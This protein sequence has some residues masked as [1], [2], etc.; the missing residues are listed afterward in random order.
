MA[1][2]KSLLSYAIERGVIPPPNPLFGLRNYPEIE[3]DFEV[4]TIPEERRAIAALLDIDV[5]VGVYA[6]VMGETAI[7]SEE[8]LRLT[9]RCLDLNARIVTVPAE[10]SKTK[11]TRHIPMSDFCKDLLGLLTRVTEDPHC[12]IRT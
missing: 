5:A 2:L 1:V 3:R 8:G 12:F 7:R 6:G 11:K 9:W 10:I 4:M